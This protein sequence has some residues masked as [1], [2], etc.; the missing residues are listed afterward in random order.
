VWLVVHP[1]VFFVI[2]CASKSLSGNVQQLLHS[3]T[4]PHGA[5]WCWPAGMNDQYHSSM[6]VTSSPHNTPA[7]AMTSSSKAIDLAM[8][9]ACNW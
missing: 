9:C 5:A 8:A 6:Q 4:L 7:R 1:V 3:K 2:L